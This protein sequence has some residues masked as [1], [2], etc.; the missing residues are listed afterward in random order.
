MARRGAAANEPQAIPRNHEIL[1]RDRGWRRIVHG[2]DSYGASRL[3][4]KVMIRE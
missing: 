3:G 2:L 4:V 1:R